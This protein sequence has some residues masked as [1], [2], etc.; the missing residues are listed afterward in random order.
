M[1]KEWV[2]RPAD[3]ILKE[4][5]PMITKSPVALATLVLS[6]FIGYSLSFIV[7]DYRKSVVKKSHYI[8]HASLGLGYSATIF[9]LVNYDV[10]SH[11]LTIE[12]ISNRM[13]LTLL[14][15]FILAFFLIIGGAIWRQFF[16]MRR[17]GE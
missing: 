9:S 4:F 15:S 11:D 10:L 7:F 2:N 17:G 13:P 3:E 14:I 8:F 16:Y 1:S 5:I 12:Q 6:T